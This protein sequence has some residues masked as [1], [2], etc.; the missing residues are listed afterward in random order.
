MALIVVVGGSVA[1]LPGDLEDLEKSENLKTP[2]SCR[3]QGSD[4]KLDLTL[5]CQL[6]LIINHRIMPCL[7]QV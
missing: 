6:D 5:F 2:K 7:M 4:Q 3:F 1:R